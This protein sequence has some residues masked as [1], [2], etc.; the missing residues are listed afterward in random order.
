[1]LIY[2][3]VRVW[4]VGGG[5][6]LAG[7][8]ETVWFSLMLFFFFFCLRIEN[9]PLIIASAQ[10]EE[11]VQAEPHRRGALG[12]RPP[13]WGQA[14]DRLW[15]AHTALGP[16]LPAVLPGARCLQDGAWGPHP[17]PAGAALLG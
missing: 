9:N 6:Q 5:G 10:L 4:Q 13:G 14:V 7:G 11:K 3:R 1:M 16:P 17:L 12:A 15:G 2:G 8:D